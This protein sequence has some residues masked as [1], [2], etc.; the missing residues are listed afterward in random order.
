MKALKSAL[1]ACGSAF[2][3]WFVFRVPGLNLPLNTKGTKEERF[4]KGTEK[5]LAGSM[6]KRHLVRN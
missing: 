1:G 6:S 3:V 5:V 2:F 4:T